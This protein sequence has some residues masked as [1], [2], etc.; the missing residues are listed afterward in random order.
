[1]NRVNHSINSVYRTYTLNISITNEQST[2]GNYLN[3]HC[4][5]WTTDFLEL[6]PYAY[7]Y[8]MSGCHRANWAKHWHIVESRYLE[9]GYLEFCETRSIYL[10]QKYISTII[11][12]WGLFTSPNYPKCKSIC[13]LDNSNPS[14]SRNR[15]LPVIM[16]V[17]VKQWPSKNKYTSVDLVDM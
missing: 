6:F 1:M 16:K 5:H 15:G 17:I 3:I 12:R 8:F 7:T 14:T 13:T 2:F 9:L 4:G 10:K 11:W